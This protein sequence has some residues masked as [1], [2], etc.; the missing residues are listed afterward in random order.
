MIAFLLGSSIVAVVVLLH[1][2]AWRHRLVMRTVGRLVVLY[3]VAVL[4]CGVL[5]VTG[6][7]PEPESWTD[8][9]R[10]L[11]MSA[12]VFLVYLSFYTAVEKDSA[13]SVILLA[14]ARQGGASRES[15]LGALDDEGMI[16]DRLRGLVRAGFVRV[17][18]SANDTGLPD[19]EIAR[20]R[21][22]RR[23]RLFLWVAR[24][25]RGAFT[26]DGIGG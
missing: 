21:L 24:V 10:A 11:L 3:P 23:G 19:H 18:R 13:S 15:L 20:F 17:E 1:V 2:L 6:A 7:L 5:V 9:V 4:A 12:A 8:A 22:T 14:A 16:L 25:A 26:P